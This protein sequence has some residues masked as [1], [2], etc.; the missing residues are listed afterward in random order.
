MVMA[1]RGSRRITVDGDE[2]RWL[3]RR[4][5]GRLRL[6]AEGVEGGRVLL[7]D[8]EPHDLFRRDG[9]GWQRTR[10][11]RTITSG[12]VAQLVR[13]ARRN[14]W[15]PEAAG[16]PM[17]IHT[18]ATDRIAPLDLEAGETDE[19]ALEDLAIAQL[20]ALCFDLSLD[21]AWRARL[22]A[23]EVGARLEIPTDD[24]LLAEE[25]RARGLRFR[26]W[27]DGL[28]SDGFV[29]FGIGSVEFP[30]VEMYTTN[31]PRIL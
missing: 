8:L 1:S 25:A 4:R 22:F 9:S 24:S 19:V 21:P 23:A 14:G 3:V 6:V 31:D 30:R 17:R 7:C 2:Y 27:N 26:A 12:L 5:D 29:V 16:G 10:Q 11:R 18:W 20:G 13:H 15:D 28:T